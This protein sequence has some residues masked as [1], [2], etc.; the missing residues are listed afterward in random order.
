MI[1]MV[2]RTR[3]LECPNCHKRLEDTKQ[4]TVTC[5]FC[6]FSFT[7]EDVAQE[8]ED[9]IRRKMIIDLRTDMEIFKARKKVSIGFMIVS[10]VFLLPV[11]I[12]A[13]IETLTIITL[14]AFVLGGFGFFLLMI[15]WDRKYESARSRASDI[16]MR[17]G[18]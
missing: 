10:F 14:L 17:R 4:Q 9:Y 8:D 1:P 5:K 15:M 12:A 2:Q 3:L 13:P 18:L 7:R 11:L 6:G 16:S